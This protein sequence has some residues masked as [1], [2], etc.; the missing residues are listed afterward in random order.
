[1]PGVGKEGGKAGLNEYERALWKW[2]NVDD[3]D[4]FLQD[5]SCCFNQ[6]RTKNIADM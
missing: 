4:G 1:M 6:E 3:L 5:V 2:V